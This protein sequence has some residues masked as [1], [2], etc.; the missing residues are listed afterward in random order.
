MTVELLL[1]LIVALLCAGGA[2]ALQRRLPPALAVRTLSWTA[3]GSASSVLWGFALLGLAALVQMPGIAS[4]AGWCRQVLPGDH[5]LPPLGGTAVLVLVAWATWSVFRFHR[6]YRRACRATAF[7]SEGLEI[8]RS[9]VP[10]AFAVPGG[11]TRRGHIVVSTGLVEHLS[12]DELAVVIAHEQAHLDHR[13]HRYVHRAELAAAAIP[14]LR[15]LAAQ[16]RFATE[17]W[18]DEEAATAIGDRRLV[19]RAV[20]RAA[21]VRTEMLSPVAMGLGGGSVTARVE[22]LLDESSVRRGVAV[23]LVAA[24][25]AGLA[26]VMVASTVQL[27]HLLTFATHVCRI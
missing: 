5:G 12:D 7:R 20:A 14:L 8:T 4:I 17:R 16:V 25:L 22:A 26:L 2:A 18:A 15:P 24:G 23:P 3:F 27:H 11:H 10:T 13:H 9:A 1:P 6:S 21:I 19:A